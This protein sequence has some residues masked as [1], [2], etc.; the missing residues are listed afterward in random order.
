M[1][2][3]LGAH[4]QTDHRKIAYDASSL[5]LKI[6]IFGLQ[7]LKRFANLADL[8]TDACCA[9]LGNA[10]SF[11]NQRAGINKRLIVSAGAAH[12]DEMPGEPVPA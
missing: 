4:R 12:F 7:N 6:C 3:E 1:A 11:D 9:D 10:L 5:L 2:C 8:G